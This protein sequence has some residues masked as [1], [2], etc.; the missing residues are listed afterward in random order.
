MPEY[1]G[2]GARMLKRNN[3]YIVHSTSIQGRHKLH[4]GKEALL[5]NEESFKKAEVAVIMNDLEAGRNTYCK[6]VDVHN[7]EQV[8]RTIIHPSMHPGACW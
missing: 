8:S 5:I 1:L 6:V 2:S 7:Y 4:A 3:N